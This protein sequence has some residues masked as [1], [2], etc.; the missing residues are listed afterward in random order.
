M[1][2]GII[3]VQGARAEDVVLTDPLGLTGSLVVRGSLERAASAL[4]GP[5]EQ[6][7]P[8]VESLLMPSDRNTSKRCHR[9]LGEPIN[10]P[11]YY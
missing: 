4:L 6:H 7:A 9:Q 8:R 1:C 11:I 5:L 10:A 3:T 2:A